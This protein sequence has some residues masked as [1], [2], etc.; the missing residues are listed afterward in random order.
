MVRKLFAQLQRLFAVGK[1]GTC[2][3]HL[4]YIRVDRLFNHLCVI[5]FEA[6][7]GQINADIGPVT[8]GLSYFFSA[9]G[10]ST[11]SCSLGTGLILSLAIS[12]FSIN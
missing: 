5:I 10:A 12:F 3:Q 6:A 2:N 11:S 8:H 4:M 1:V 7:I 9:S